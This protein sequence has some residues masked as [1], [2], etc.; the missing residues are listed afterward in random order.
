MEILTENW[1]PPAVKSVFVV[2]L[3]DHIIML[4][5]AVG[6]RRCTHTAHAFFS[7]LQALF[8]FTAASL[9]PHAI[10]S[11]SGRL[12]EDCEPRVTSLVL[13]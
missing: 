13:H 6:S 7:A 4:R 10:I 11:V 3:A 1:I 9:V 12:R 5:P 8:A 2:P